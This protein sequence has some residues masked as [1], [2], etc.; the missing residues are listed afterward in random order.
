[1]WWPL[2]KDKATQLLFQ[3]DSS[4]A[5]N[6]DGNQSL[7]YHAP[8]L[9]ETTSISR[10]GSGSGSEDNPNSYH[11]TI[12]SSPFTL[13]KDFDEDNKDVSQP[14]RDEELAIFGTS[15][16]LITKP[17]QTPLFGITQS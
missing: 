3:N 6:E 17:T 9:L 13:I 14:T 16:K 8:S 12:G 2:Q 4:N 11:S 10:D 5:Y 15:D 1:M 7:S